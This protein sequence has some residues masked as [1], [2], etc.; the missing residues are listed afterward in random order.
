[1]VE[2]NINIEIHHQSSNRDYMDTLYTKGHLNPV[3]HNLG[4]GQTATCTY[5]NAVPQLAH[6][7]N[8][9][10][11]A[12]EQD[13]QAELLQHCPDPNIRYVLVGAVPSENTTIGREVNVPKQIW[14]A[15][16]CARRDKHVET[17][18]RSGAFIAPNR[19]DNNVRVERITV[20]DLQ[21]KLGGGIQVFADQCGI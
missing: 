6:F 4:D 14:S 8:V 5:T 19:N 17:G 15:F 1:M 18:F 11:G 16:C 12:H 20:Q 7:N 13:L 3:S 21:T 2:E 10:W 9:V